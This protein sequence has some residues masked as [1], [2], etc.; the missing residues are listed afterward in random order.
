MKQTRRR[1]AKEQ[2]R[3]IKGMG[4]RLDNVEKR[5]AHIGSQWEKFNLNKLERQEQAKEIGNIAG[6]PAIPWML[7]MLELPGRDILGASPSKP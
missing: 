5:I 3:T 2:E 6:P 1:R 7:D 4:K